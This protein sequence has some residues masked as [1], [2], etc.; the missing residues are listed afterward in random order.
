MFYQ[1]MGITS[2]ADKKN[3]LVPILAFLPDGYVEPKGKISLSYK[4]HEISYIYSWDDEDLLIKME[5]Q[6][7]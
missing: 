7:K 1:Q 3:S 5:K 4:D 2:A 6:K